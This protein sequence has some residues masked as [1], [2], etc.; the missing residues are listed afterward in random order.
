MA[1]SY[2]YQQAWENR[3]A[4]RLDK[5]TNW[6]DVCDVVY[7]DT[8]I[9]NFPLI[10]VGGEPAVAT[11][12]NTA[13]GRS[14]L[15]NVIP[16]VDTTETNQTLTISI[17]EIN[18]AYVDYADEAQSNYAKMATLGDLLG[19]KMMERV[20]TIVLA[21]HASWTDIGDAGGGAVGL[22]STDLTI[23][24]TN[25]D[26]VIRGVIEQIQTANGFDL[27]RQNGGFV[28]WRPADWTKLTTFMQANGYTFADEALKTGGRVGQEAMGLFHYVSTSHASGGHVM[29]GVRK[30]QKLGILNR[31]FGKTFVNEMPASSTAGSLSGTQIHTR[32]DYGLLVPTNLLPVIYDIN[33]D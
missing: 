4:Q 26:D 18:S 17:A 9:H 28:V 23:S 24:A 16:F 29:A 32:M 6:K 15:S 7:S 1:S 22:G 20:E 14:T 19:K 3:L 10:T 12:T 11:L 8:Q 30:V 2:I 33:T 31:T 25:I 27:Y 5:P 21:N 13:A